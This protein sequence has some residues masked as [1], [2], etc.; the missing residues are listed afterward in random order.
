MWAFRALCYSLSPAQREAGTGGS[1]YW[2][3]H[4]G[5]GTEAPVQFPRASLPHMGQLLK[6]FGDLTS[7]KGLKNTS[8]YFLE[9]NT[10]QE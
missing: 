1:G 8:L 4:R 3:G 5:L 9:Q 6:T 10:W 2:E 7:K